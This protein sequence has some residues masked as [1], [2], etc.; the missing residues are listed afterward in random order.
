MY[1]QIPDDT[2]ILITHTPP[3]GIL[4]KLDHSGSV[5]GAHVGSKELLQRLDHLK[6]LKLVT[7]GHIHNQN[8]MIELNG[9]KFVNAAICNEQYKPTQPYHVIEL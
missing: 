6:N 4:D 8:S 3:Y 7:M 2:E 1:S 9:I 5:P